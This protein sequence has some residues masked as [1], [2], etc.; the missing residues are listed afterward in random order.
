MS[1]ISF[2]ET[3]KTLHGNEFHDGYYFQVV[4]ACLSSDAIVH[5]IYLPGNT[6][7]PKYEVMPRDHK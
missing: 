5:K 4:S 3:L 2:F 7:I 6:D 1:E